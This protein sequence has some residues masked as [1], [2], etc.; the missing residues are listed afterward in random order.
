MAS[1]ILIKRSATPGKVPTTAQLEFGELALNYADGSLYYKT[2]GGA[3]VALI[4]AIGA[5]GPVG[6]TGPVGA[7]GPTGVAGATGPAGDA[8]ANIDGG[9]SDSV[10]GGIE[11]IDCGTA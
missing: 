5:T 7:T 4:G 10:Y 11:I 8:I 3:G 1:K 9:F 2:A 6:P